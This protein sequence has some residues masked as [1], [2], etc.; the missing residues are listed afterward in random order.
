M[1]HSVDGLQTDAGTAQA[2]GG[3]ADKALVLRAGGPFF[4]RAFDGF[5]TAEE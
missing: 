2:P 5:S 1:R 4:S 3:M